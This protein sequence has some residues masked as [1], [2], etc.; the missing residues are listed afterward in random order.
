[1]KKSIIGSALVAFSSLNSLITLAQSDWQTLE[2]FVY[3]ENRQAAL[4]NFNP[5][6]PEWYFYSCIEL[7]LAG[8]FD[9]VDK[10]LNKWEKAP[11]SD[12]RQIILH[13]QLLLNAKADPDALFKYLEEH[14]AFNFTATR[15][16]P[17]NSE[18]RQ[19]PSVL[20]ENQLTESYWQNLYL[21]EMLKQ[22][23]DLIDQSI[24][25][26][27]SLTKD[28]KR[29]T[30]LLLCYLKTPTHP[31]L[32]EL[33]IQDLKSD[34]TT[35]FGQRPIHKQLTLPQLEQLAEKMPELL[36]NTKFVSALLKRQFTQNPETPEQQ[37]AMFQQQLTVLK[38]LSK[39]YDYL[40]HLIIGQ[41]LQIQWETAKPDPSLFIQ[42]LETAQNEEKPVHTKQD[43]Y[44]FKQLLT[45]LYQVKTD[46]FNAYHDVLL[47][48]LTDHTKAA[49]FIK[50][51]GDK[52]YKQ[53]KVQSDLLYGKMTPEEVPDWI[54]SDTLRT[55][56]DAT[57]LEF[58]HTAPKP[59]EVDQKVSL[60]LIIKNIP[61]LTVNIYELNLENFYRTNSGEPNLE[62]SL[63]G[64]IPTHSRTIK[65]DHARQLQSL[66]S[67]DLPELAGPGVFIV[68][69]IGNGL[70]CR[71]I[72]RKGQLNFITKH[73]A[74]G[75]AFQLIKTGEKPQPVNGAIELSG[76]RYEANDQGIIFMPY[77]AKHQT[78]SIL[79]LADGI[80]SR[81]FFTPPRADF[82][83]ELGTVIER[84]S[85][86][87][88]NTMPLLI[89]PKLTRAGETV[90][91]DQLV[92]PQ[93]LTAMTLNNNQVIT[94]TQKL[95]I[96]AGQT[97]F[98]L[99]L[100]IPEDLKSLKITLEAEIK[101]AYQAQPIKLSAST[102]NALQDLSLTD[103]TVQLFFQQQDGK[104]IVQAI[105]H[106][107]EPVTNHPLS[108]ELF[109]EPFSCFKSTKINLQTDRQG[110]VVLGD[111]A[112]FRCKVEATGAQ[113][114]FTYEP[115]DY[116]PGE[117]AAVYPSAQPIA[118][119]LSS[120][121]QDHQWL[122]YRTTADGLLVEDA[123]NRL[124]HTPGQLQI[125]PLPVGF[126][127]LIN[128]NTTKARAFEIRETTRIRDFL[129]SENQAFTAP[130][131]CFTVTKSTADAKGLHL[132][133]GGDY[134][135][136]RITIIGSTYDFAN[137]RTLAKPLPKSRT[138]ELLGPDNI[139]SS[140]GK[141]SEEFQYILQ[142]RQEGTRIG[143]MLDR[144]GLIL[145][146][147]EL[148]VT[149]TQ[150]NSD[151]QDF[152]LR[153]APGR[154]HALKEFAGRYAKSNEASHLFHSLARPRP[155]EAATF[156]FKASPNFMA[157]ERTTDG[158]GQLF[159]PDS[160]LGAATKFAV[161]IE[162]PGQKMILNIERDYQA[163]K[164]TDTRLQTALDATRLFQENWQQKV[165]QPGESITLDTQQAPQ[166]LT[167]H[168]FS[169]AFDL[170]NG[171]LEG[172]LQDFAFLKTWSSLSETEKRA[173]YSQFTCHELH[174]FLSV[175]DTPFFEKVVKPALA[176]KLEKTLVDDW[177]LGGD[178]TPWLDPGRFQTLNLLELALLN[179]AYPDQK[180]FRFINDL[181]ASHPLS[182]TDI[183]AL[184]NLIMT[185][186]DRASDKLL[187]ENESE[188]KPT[189]APIQPIT[190]LD[191]PTQ[192]EK[193]AYINS[194]KAKS[195]DKGALGVNLMLIPNAP[196]EGPEI[197]FEEAEEDSWG[198]DDD[199]LITLSAMPKALY[200]AL[201]PTK[202]FIEHNYYDIK[203][204]NTKSLTSLNPFWQ[205]VANQPNQPSTGLV[206][207][208]KTRNEALAALALSN[209]PH[210]AEKPQIT[211]K[212]NKLQIA[213]DSPTLVYY[214]QMVPKPLVADPTLMVKQNFIDPDSLLIEESEQQAHYLTPKDGQ[215]NMV[216]G[217]KYVTQTI[218][219][220]LSPQS[221]S[222]KL[223]VQLPTGSLP[224]G[225]AQTTKSHIIHLQ[226]YETTINE[227]AFYFPADGDF[228]QYPP[229]ATADGKRSAQAEPFTFHVAPDKIEI[230]P[231]SWHQI[232]Q[233]GTDAQ[234]L[235]WLATANL[236]TTDLNKIHFRL[237]DRDFY[238]KT[239]ELLRK[240]RH[241]DAGV[242]SFAVYHR[243]L[244]SLK[245]W[246]SMSRM[247]RESGSYLKSELLSIDPQL[248]N[249]FRMVD[250][251]PLINA[252]T[253]RVKNQ[254]EILN[255][256]L[257]GAYHHFLRIAALYPEMN[258]VQQLISAS[259][260]ALQDRMPESRKLLNSVDRQKIDSQIQYD[261]LDLYL[262]FSEGNISTARRIAERYQAYPVDHWRLK[263][264]T[265]LSQLNQA[266]SADQSVT[267][268][269]SE[270]EK[271]TAR[272]AAEPSLRLDTK[273]GQP[274]L[275]SRNLNDCTMNIYEIDL[276]QRFS[277]QPFSVSS[278][279]F[280]PVTKPNWSGKITITPDP[281]NQGQALTVPE[282]YRNK[283]FLL[284][285]VSGDQRST[286]MVYFSKLQWFVENRYA[287]I[288]VTAENKPLPGAYVKVY[289]QV[290]GQSHF[291]KDGY[292]D[293][294]G[295]F[296]Y[297]S[298]SSLPQGLTLG[299]I[300]NLA[301]LVQS[302]Q[303]GGIVTEAT[304]P[305]Y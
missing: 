291:I 297:L 126:W 37:L 54:S 128:R 165:L 286:G 261:Y 162:K 279:S 103:Y 160:K 263:F 243:D 175:Y 246:L 15:I 131:H 118:Y 280:L 82:K 24:L 34:K 40:R 188:R 17:A 38:P 39:R 249:F 233:Y 229:T 60:P 50:H 242:W 7:Q 269:L 102:N 125:A 35:H 4:K 213:V 167:I 136:A 253:H 31:R 166:W 176:N 204:K 222:V 96:K 290:N 111:L 212:G 299:N 130:T 107:G 61:A 258:D 64:L 209:L 184:F 79:L 301:I 29:R 224:L 168:T 78:E 244:T 171:L 114:I 65:F 117:L 254:L 270:S 36:E 70:N 251:S 94:A 256:D 121:E 86:I 195:S 250:F 52:T 194:I 87:P 127:Q 153:G 203:Y 77:P 158:D 277:E 276:E 206:F 27:L 138:T 59:Y 137:L 159:I 272:A 73:L 221:R 259:F 66:Q 105:G 109:Y 255:N 287:Q 238:Q 278:A 113:T 231:E 51:L 101:E 219:T 215:L 95:E 214:K 23:P 262:S 288:K 135:N 154:H 232:S 58:R 264:T 151:M 20:P 156:D 245:Q 230:H 265:A 134:R 197:V 91:L 161:S 115:E 12:Q 88:G 120:L 177:L 122:L 141:V 172:D 234:V 292:T 207:A 99:P 284:E 174:L 110:Q 18:T 83:L 178:L 192:R 146:P 271:Q 152:G 217:K 9:E 47:A 225:G 187:G 169:D 84:E 19:F 185:Q 295:R 133:L 119:P 304:A 196:A 282:A 298:V 74:Q 237:K 93:V 274:I 236:V 124:T 13:R 55:W 199:I 100:N 132:S 191:E 228:T 281:E 147:I 6:S 116:N 210:Q 123:T 81:K 25:C 33:I 76:T 143:N 104:T 201:T 63:S 71:A 90:A 303:F 144:P 283:A 173:K 89:T 180:V 48:M 189:P 149:S 44:E 53:L 106:N 49:T 179:Q 239:I 190:P 98:T 41:M 198:M 30:H 140:E 85:L 302:D 266:A 223:L 69:L 148:M 142:R 275:F 10:L 11:A 257:R 21:E 260:L 181:V 164:Q 293:L 150:S 208:T 67:L 2:K 56:L 16:E 289:A 28:T 5:G 14:F 211:R 294:R 240:R 216:R 273:S 1:M 248:D 68:D 62:L 186:S 43:D 72:I 139:F 235:N 305:A 129:I 183:N 157:I 97:Q 75:I 205:D 296:D 268:E 22:R 182:E 32:L 42:Y 226:P 92:N 26:D 8:Q 202:A 112:D 163:G 3:A 218:V 57:R 241:F 108:V 300:Q 200:K 220:N 80:V 170:L 145:N 285:V 45:N 155:V 46:R 227:N 267:A 252:R 193:I 247:R